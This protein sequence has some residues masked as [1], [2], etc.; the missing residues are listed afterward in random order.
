MSRLRKEGMGLMRGNRKDDDL[1]FVGDTAGRGQGE[2]VVDRTSCFAC[3]RG[4]SDRVLRSSL[5]ASWLFGSRLRRFLHSRIRYHHLP[6]RISS[7]ASPALDR[8]TSPFTFSRRS[9]DGSLAVNGPGT[10]PIRRL[11]PKVRERG[12]ESE[13]VR[14]PVRDGD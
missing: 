10:Q 1:V 3:R 12:D 13:R 14:E 4:I 11:L 9:P 6:P 2:R 8:T 7:S 5:A